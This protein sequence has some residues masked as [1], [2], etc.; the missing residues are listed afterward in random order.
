MYAECFVMMLVL[1]CFFFWIVI[2]LHILFII[3]FY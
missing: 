3:I 2:V 1:P